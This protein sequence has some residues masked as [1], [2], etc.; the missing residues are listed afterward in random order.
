MHN[1]SISKIDLLTYTSWDGKQILL[2]LNIGEI[3]HILHSD[4]FI[5][6]HYKL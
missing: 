2:V 1:S 6:Q 4:H 5:H 3:E